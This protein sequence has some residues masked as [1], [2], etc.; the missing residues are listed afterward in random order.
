MVQKSISVQQ[1]TD[2]FNNK[3]SWSHGFIC[4]TFKPN[5]PKGDATEWYVYKMFTVK[6]LY[7]ISVVQAENYECRLAEFSLGR[8]YFCAHMAQTT[9]LCTGMTFFLFYKNV[10]CCSGQVKK[11]RK[12][13][14]FYVFYYGKLIFGC[15]KFDPVAV[16]IQGAMKKNNY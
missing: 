16:D 6:S 7:E 14:Q 15:G 9:A 1:C 5:G 11:A 2:K 8:L 13:R 3:S 12:R 4:C 10:C